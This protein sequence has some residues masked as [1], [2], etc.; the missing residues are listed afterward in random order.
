MFKNRRYKGLG[1]EIE[2]KL[3]KIIFDVTLVVVAIWERIF[4]KAS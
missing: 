2:S 3:F 4:V 1:Q